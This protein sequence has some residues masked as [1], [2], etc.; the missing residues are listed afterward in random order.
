MKGHYV[1]STWERAVA[2][3][4][5]V[6]CIPYRYEYQLFDLGDGIR[7]RPDFYL[8]RENLWL[9]VK[10]YMLETDK[11][12]HARFVQA[13][14]KLIIFGKQQWNNLQVTGRI[15]LPF[16]VSEFNLL[17]NYGRQSLTDEL[18]T[19]VLNGN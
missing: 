8:T 2:D 6:R 5:Y 11:I 7:Y 16:A 4:L 17:S 19:G 18:T 14:H 9:E 13:G 12:K 1:R 3:W 15:Y 10:G